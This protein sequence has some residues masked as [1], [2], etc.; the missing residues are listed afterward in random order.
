MLAGIHYK[1]LALGM[2]QVNHYERISVVRWLANHS[3]NPVVQDCF[4]GGKNMNLLFNF[5]IVNL[6][7]KSNVGREKN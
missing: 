7:L 5:N 1:N 3:S 2:F 4:L 6:L